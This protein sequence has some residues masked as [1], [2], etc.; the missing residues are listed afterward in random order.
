ME[1][2]IASE[3]SGLAAAQGNAADLIHVTQLPII[4]EQLRAVSQ[5]ID[6][7]TQEAVSLV[8]TED[9]VKSVKKTRTELNRRFASFEEQRKAVKAAVLGPYEAFER[10]YK[11]C[12]SDKFKAAD[13]ALK[14]K[15]SAT[16]SALLEDK[17][18]SIRAY[19]DE[20]AQS[21]HVD[22]V[23]FECSG[24]RVILS[25]SAKSAKEQCKAFLD[26]VAADVEAIGQSED[27]AEIMAEYRRSLDLPGSM[28]AVS[29]RRK[30]VEE[31]RQRR[32]ARAQAVEA[33][34][35]A[36]EKVAAFASPVQ[37]WKAPHT[38]EA[39]AEEPVLRCT[40]TVQATKPQLKKLK[41]FMNQEGIRYE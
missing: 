29:S 39:A 35:Q 23:P 3:E 22:F 10:T 38:P 2:N 16:E 36:A 25:T 41:E 37:V 31:E 34:H 26:R 8:C 1:G 24:V 15:I 7:M 33:E 18:S 11:E 9:T 40:F 32:E 6:V 17:L 28:L 27:A 20:Y 21:V 13:G 19:Y 14:G 4:E 12:I 30:A 5:E